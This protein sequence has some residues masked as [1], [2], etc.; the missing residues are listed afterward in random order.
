MQDLGKRNSQQILIVGAGF[1]GATIARKLAEH[2][3]Q[4]TVIDKRGH[5]AG[6]AYDFVN[7]YGIRIHRYGPHLFHTSNQN[8]YEWLSQFTEWVPYQHK[9]KALLAN[10]SLVTLPPNKDTVE[11]VGR[12]NIVNIFYRP[13]TKK[14]WGLELD[15]IDPDIVNRVKPREDLN[16]LYFPDD[17]YQCLPKDGYTKLI[18]NMLDH[19]LI[20]ISLN[21]PY[22]EGMEKMYVHTF[23]SMPIDE[24][25]K[26]DCGQL[27]YRSIKFHTQ[28]VP[29]PS[30]FPVGVV[31][32]TH[33]EAYTR[34]T[35]WKNFPGHGTNLGYTTITTEEPCDYVNNNYERY[36]PV[37]D[38]DGKNRAHYQKYKSKI[39][40]SM[41]FVGRCGL[42]AYLDMHQAVNSAL[43][44][45]EDFIK[46][47]A[48]S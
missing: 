37:K 28:T 25:F 36:Y 16:E 2:G 44:V 43:K 18:Q 13:Y 1:S 24:F 17:V 15:Q 40:S 20:K 45:A 11:K 47:V 22:A 38:F 9:V 30:L 33:D 32:F 19:E 21:T 41:T 12:D 48:T 3:Y 26:Y 5:V 4:V 29:V 35:E 14:M 8:V 42:Y 39:S 27:P 46:K 6:N 23:N 31:N 10:G 34:V 7:E